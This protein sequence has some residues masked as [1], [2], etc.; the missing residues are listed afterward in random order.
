MM[1]QKRSTKYV[2]LDVH[3]ATTVTSVREKG[4]RV[5]ARTV[6]P[7]EA[8]VIV[9]YFRGMRGAV[10]VTFE[11]ATQAQW[12]HD[13]LVPVV[14]RVLV[15]DR[16][17]R[18]QDGNKGDHVDADALSELLRRGALRTVIVQAKRPKHSAGTKCAL[19][20]HSHRTPQLTCSRATTNRGSERSEQPH[21]A[22]P[23]V[24]CSDR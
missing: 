21:S 4:G 5:I 7:T 12:L 22:T 2:A 8:A 14:D 9:D 17:G 20:N 23:A 24:R 19:D 6:L 18:S 15:C 10:H 1:L 11:E 13:L 3:Q 16:R